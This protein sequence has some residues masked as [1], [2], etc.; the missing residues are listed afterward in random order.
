MPCV[1]VVI[2]LFN[3]AA[4]IQ[5]CLDSVAQQTLSDF[6]V[7]VVDDGSTDGGEAIAA[8]HSDPRFRVLR[9]PNAGPGAARNRGI[10]AAGAEYIAFL[11]GDDAWLPTFLERN[12]SLLDRHPA[13]ACVSGCWTDFPGGVSAACTWSRRGIQ[14][15][16][17]MTSAVTPVLLFNRTVM[18]MTS[19]TTVVRTA[20]IR[21]CGGFQA[22]GCR[23]GEDQ[24]LWLKLLLSRP[25]YLHLQ[26]LTDLHREAS[27]LSGSYTGRAPSS[28]SC[29]IP[30]K[31]GPAAPGT[32]RFVRSALCSARLQDRLHAGVLE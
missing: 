1:S 22:G 27:V 21:H 12:I 2:P 17:H 32:A 9:Q 30:S 14:E 10:A 28:R 18:Y 6:E 3:K 4:Y 23:F 13:V 25:V 8:S 5:R 29:P 19:C 11:D 7:I 15:G 20:A 31:S 24:S 16:V 26:E